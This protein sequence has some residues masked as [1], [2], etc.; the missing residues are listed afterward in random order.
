[1]KIIQK[2][3][4]GLLTVVA[5][6]SA[7][8]SANLI[9][10]VDAGD[11]ATV[12]SVITGTAQKIDAGT[13]V[14]SGANGS[15]LT[16]LEIAGGLVQYAASGNVG[17]QVTFNGGN[18]E[19]TAAANIPALVMTA[20]GTV[21]A[22]GDG[23]LAGLSGAS[24]LTIAGIGIVTPADLSAAAAPV[25]ISGIVNFGASAA[26]KLPAADVNVLSG[27]LAKVMAATADCAPDDM[28]VQSGGVLE[29]ADSV[30]VPADTGADLFG[31]LKFNTGS[32][33]KLGNAAVWA[34]A[35]TV[36]TAL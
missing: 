30:L 34:R 21:T 2:L 13:L 33:L 19:S 3:T 28:I 16:N 36:G 10:D 27:G 5:T 18:L 7:G 4:L 24:K 17:A 9:I 6:S 35:I 31:T 20:A 15:S 1:M 25:D 22:G 23:A 11:T 32:T 8:F 29:V 14:M 12:S 26:S